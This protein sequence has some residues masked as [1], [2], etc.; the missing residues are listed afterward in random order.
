MDADRYRARAAEFDA[1]PFARFLGMRVVDLAPGRAV[2]EM[3][4]R[5]DY[6]NWGG[7]THGGAI[8]ALADHAFGCSLNAGERTYVAVQFGTNFIA[9]PKAGETLRA[10]ARVLHAGRKVG[11]VQV[12]VTAEGGRLIATA[13]GTT[14]VLEPRRA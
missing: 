11:I 8:M 13:S 6:Q 9:A 2:V 3:P 10:E 7:I 12:T 14:V 1:S 4:V 5:E